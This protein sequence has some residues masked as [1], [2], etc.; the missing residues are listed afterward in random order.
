[1]GSGRRDLVKAPAGG[2]GGASAVHDSRRLRGAKG[3]SHEGVRSTVITAIAIALVAGS[4][5]GVVA[6]GETAAPELPAE[7]TGHIECGPSVGA[8][9]WEQ[10]ATLSD[11]RLEG[12]YYYSGAWKG[13]IGGRAHTATLRMENDEGA[14]QGSLVS[15]NLPDGS[16]TTGSAVLVGEG[17]YEGLVAIWEHRVPLP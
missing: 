17:A 14:W 7:F 1:M 2:A 11:P 13:Y 5:G 4:A 10:P 8:S 9:M 15:A 3:G 12:T 6:Q 16:W